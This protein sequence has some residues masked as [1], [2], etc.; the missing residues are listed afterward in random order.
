MLLGSGYSIFD[1]PSHLVPTCKT[2][3]K[4]KAKFPMF[5]DEHAVGAHVIIACPKNY[6][7]VDNFSDGKITCTED[8]WDSQ[9]ED[10]DIICESKYTVTYL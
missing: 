3:G 5:A 4:W 7:L 8:G 1:I 9:E 2:F 10:L 6:R